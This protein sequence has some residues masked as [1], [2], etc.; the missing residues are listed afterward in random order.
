MFL[1]HVPLIILSA[2]WDSSGP[3]YEEDA[4]EDT[5]VEAHDPGQ[6]DIRVDE[7]GEDPPEEACTTPI[8][9]SDFPCGSMSVCRDDR[10]M[11]TCRIIPCEETCGTTCCSGA[12]C[13]IKNT[14]T[15]EEGTTC[16]QL[17]D[18]CAH[19]P[20]EFNEARCLAPG[21]VEEDGSI[22]IEPESYCSYC[23]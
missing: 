15:C 2:C 5:I 23:S 13:G 6:E 16:H 17:V 3:A 4:A 21:T 12:S 14:V 19:W 11:L 18:G 10:T 1:L 20:M 7:E 9:F 8:C 22:W